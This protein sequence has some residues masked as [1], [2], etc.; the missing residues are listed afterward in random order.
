MNLLNS[1]RNWMSSRRT[2]NELANLS[3]DSLADIGLTRYDIAT[4]SRRL[5]R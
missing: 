4:V 2:M 3:N 1:A 5:A